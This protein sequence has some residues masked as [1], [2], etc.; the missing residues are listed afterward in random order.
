MERTKSR[1]V[2]L[3]VTLFWCGWTL[4]GGVSS[5][6]MEHQKEAKAAGIP[7]TTC[8]YCHMDKLPKKDEG[9]HDPNERGK[10]LIAEKE[11][12][13]AKAVDGSWLKDYPGDKK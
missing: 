10:W 1:F 9:K 4:L 13:H 2:A 3:I 11:K 6:T 12:R 7:A 5:A 8:N